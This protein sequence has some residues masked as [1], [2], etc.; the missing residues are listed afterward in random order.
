MVCVEKE[1]GIRQKKQKTSCISLKAEMMLDKGA[2]WAA[3][4]GVAA[5]DV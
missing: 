3:V 4:Y 1:I 2:W 5:A